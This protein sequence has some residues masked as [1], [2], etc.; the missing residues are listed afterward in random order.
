MDQMLHGQKIYMT[1]QETLVSDLKI[2]DL[3]GNIYALEVHANILLTNNSG[4]TMLERIQ[5]SCFV[6]GTLRVCK[7]MLIDGNLR[8]MVVA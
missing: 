8:L 1:E 4:L 3:R 7:L 2:S 5:P 6:L